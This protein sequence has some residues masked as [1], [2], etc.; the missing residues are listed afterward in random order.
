MIWT[1][2]FNVQPQGAIISRHW[3]G[4]LGLNLV[5][6]ETSIVNKNCWLFITYIRGSQTFIA[7]APLYNVS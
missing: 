2:W 7:C 1:M 3:Y 4:S 5:W 6:N